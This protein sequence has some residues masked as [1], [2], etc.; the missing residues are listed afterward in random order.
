MVDRKK[1]KNDGEE[2]GVTVEV[3]EVRTYLGATDNRE[4]RSGTTEGLST[5]QIVQMGRR[6]MMGTKK[7]TKK[8]LRRVGNVVWYTRCLGKFP[9]PEERSHDTGC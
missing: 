2:N 9:N 8:R 7:S 6:E 4:R 3:Q 5:V 1:E